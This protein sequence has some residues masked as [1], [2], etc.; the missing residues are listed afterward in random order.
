MCVTSWLGA[1]YRT[2]PDDES[3]PKSCSTKW[4]PLVLAS[5]EPGA[6]DEVRAPLPARLILAEGAAPSTMVS[7]VAAAPKLPPTFVGVGRGVR[8]LQW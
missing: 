5:A 2:P 8:F 3:P 7:V 1:R 4:P 6:I